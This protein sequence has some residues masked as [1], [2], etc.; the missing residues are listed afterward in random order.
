[1][2]VGIDESTA[3]VVSPSG[4]WEVIGVSQAVVYDAR[5]SSL[6]PTG[7]MLGAA[8]IQVHVLPAGSRFD[9]A[10]GKATLP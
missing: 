10:T 1:V 6:T 2:G 9:L 8:N 7:A 4:P 5:R 3:L